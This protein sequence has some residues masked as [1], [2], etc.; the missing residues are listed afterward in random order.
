[1]AKRNLPKR[2]FK[3]PDRVSRYQHD[4][5]PMGRMKRMAREYE[6]VLQNIEFVLV[7]SHRDDPEIDDRAVIE[8]LQASLTDAEPDDERVDG[9]VMDLQAMREFREDITAAVWRDAIHVVADS[10]RRHSELRPGET[11][12]LSFVSQYVK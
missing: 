11:S 10:V 1:M 9:L 6:D 12:Y 2:L 8:A 5:S 4:R 7:N 3:A